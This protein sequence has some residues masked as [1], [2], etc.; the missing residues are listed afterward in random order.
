MSVLIKL[1]ATK[2]LM[3][4]SPTNGTQNIQA[5][6]LLVFF[7]ACLDNGVHYN[8]YSFAGHLC[9]VFFFALGL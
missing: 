5:E 9:T 2:R 7:N 3:P 4:F 1:M 8:I 6:A